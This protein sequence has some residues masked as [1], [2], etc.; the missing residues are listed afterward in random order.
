MSTPTVDRSPVIERH[1]CLL[2]CE[3][4]HILQIR[5]KMFYLLSGVDASAICPL[6]LCMNE[7]K[8]SQAL[9]MLA[10]I[11]RASICKRLLPFGDAF[12]N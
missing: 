8:S 11:A 12:G 9:R 4:I 6:W 10:Q 3:P 2:R 5:S 1:M 7:A